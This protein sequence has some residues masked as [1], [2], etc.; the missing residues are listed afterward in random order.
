MALLDCCVDS[1]PASDICLLGGPEQ[2]DLAVFLGVSDIFLVERDGAGGLP[3]G[4]QPTARQFFDHI[5]NILHV[6]GFH[7]AP[8]PVHICHGGGR[9]QQRLRLFPWKVQRLHFH[10]NVLPHGILISVVDDFLRLLFQQPRTVLFLL[11][12][13]FVV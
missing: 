3:L 6:V 1:V 7:L 10:Q 2:L 5:P 13:H 4:F 12:C 9:S 11:R 8:L